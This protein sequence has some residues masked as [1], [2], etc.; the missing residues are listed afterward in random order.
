[1]PYTVHAFTTVALIGAPIVT[2][3]AAVVV[4]ERRD[5]VA[6]A[7]AER[8]ARRRRQVAQAADYTARRAA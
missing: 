6:R 1:M 2:L 8:V 7:N 5:H 4:A 3:L